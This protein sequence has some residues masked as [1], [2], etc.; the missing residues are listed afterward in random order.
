MRYLIVLI[1]SVLS[2]QISHSQ[3]N[4]L[5][6]FLGG[7][8]FIGDVG[9]TDYIAPNQFAFG[10]IYK[11]NRSKRHSYRASI[12][13]SEL[14]G[15]DTN[16]DDPRR[17]Q[18][19]YEFNSNILELSIGMEFTF[20]DFNLHSGTK[21]ATPYLFA[22]ISGAHHDNHYFLNGVQTNENASSWAF[23]IP[24]GLGFKTSFVEGFILGIEIGARYTF[25]DELDGSLP[26]KPEN[27][28]Y[29]FGNINNNDWYMF[30]GI[31]LTYTF[32]ENPCYCFN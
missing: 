1:L 22:G 31:T 27:Q 28:P 11:W 21:V 7:S 18:R 32:G 3:I 4:E 17:I 5:G 6:V 10:G 25:S 15:I 16:S 14:E 2:I 30:T 8:N 20:V 19:G 23:G 29:R 13:F 26:S 24:M 9:A 12:I